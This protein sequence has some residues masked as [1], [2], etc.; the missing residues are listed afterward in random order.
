MQRDWD[1]IRQVLTDVE[2]LSPRERDTVS[3]G[4][5]RD[6]TDEAKHAYGAHIFLLKDAGFLTGIDASTVGEKA[7]LKSIARGKGYRIVIGGSDPTWQS[8]D[9]ADNWRCAELAGACV[10]FA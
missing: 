2:S 7:L 5:N 3:L 6:E 10:S 1:V 9:T 4:V 8:G